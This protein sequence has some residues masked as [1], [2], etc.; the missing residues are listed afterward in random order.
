MMNTT[1]KILLIIT[2]VL[3]SAATLV[4]GGFWFGRN[5]GARI[6]FFHPPA[7]FSQGE[8][9][10]YSGCASRPFGGRP[11]REFFRGPSSPGPVAPGRQGMMPWAFSPSGGATVEVPDMAEA[12]E[13]FEEYLAR[14]GNDDLALHEVMLFE[15]NGYAIVTERSSGMGALEL[16]L[17]Y[18]TM[19]VFPEYGPAR[20]WNLKYGMMG[21]GMMRWGVTPSQPVNGTNSI[22]MPVSAVEA[23]DLAQEYLDQN[24]PGAII[25]GEGM[26]FYGYFTFDYSQDGKPTGML[27]V[28]GFNSQ[29][30]PHTW[31]G[32]FID[33]WE[34]QE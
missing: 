22:E 19:A 8:Q 18:E 4:A 2:L 17:D 5:M 11:A 32:N 29:I 10:F 21:R 7:I 1:I 14:W 15:R 16:L 25:A 13:I 26:A 27:S 6:S 12:R 23:K 28:N 24:T 31:H 9:G 3:F 30:W 33:E 34:A 20:M